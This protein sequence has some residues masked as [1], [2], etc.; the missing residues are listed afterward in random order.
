MVWATST[1]MTVAAAMTDPTEPL[2]VP[3]GAIADGGGGQDD[4]DAT[5]PLLVPPPGRI[6]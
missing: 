5:V 3:S 1:T 6:A 4:T 2:A